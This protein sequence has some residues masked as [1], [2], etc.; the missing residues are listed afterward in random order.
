MY[1]NNSGPQSKQ[2]IKIKNNGINSSAFG[3]STT[4]E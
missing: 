4:K 2:M 1:Y 3:D